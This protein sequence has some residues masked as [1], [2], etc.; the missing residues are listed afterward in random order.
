MAP[1]T[2]INCVTLPRGSSKVPCHLFYACFSVVWFCEHEHNNNWNVVWICSHLLV[3][4][5]SVTTVLSRITRWDREKVC[6]GVARVQMPG[7]ISMKSGMH[8]YKVH[9]GRTLLMFSQNTRNRWHDVFY[10]KR[11][12]TFIF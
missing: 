5:L 12:L 7:R 3:V 6:L 10:Q 2:L 1:N 4:T 9:I 8:N 11:V